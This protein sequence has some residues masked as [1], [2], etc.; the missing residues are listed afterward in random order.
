MII[1]FC[2]DLCLCENLEKP[3]LDKV[4]NEVFGNHPAILNLEGP[5]LDNSLEYQK[6]FKSGPVIS[7]HS[8]TP[9][10]L[11]GLGVIGVSLANNHIMDYGEKGLLSTANMLE[12]IGV[13][14]SGIA[15]SDNFKDHF[16]IKDKGISLC[17]IS[18]CEEE[19]G[20]ANGNLGGSNIFKLH[21]LSNKIKIFC[22]LY[23]HVIISYHGGLEFSSVPSPDLVRNMRYLTEQGASMVLCHHTHRVNSFEYWNDVPIFFGLGNF[24]FNKSKSTDLWRESLILTIEFSKSSLSV[25]SSSVIR[26]NKYFTDFDFVT[27]SKNNVYINRDIEEYKLEWQREI[28]QKLDFH[29]ST[30]SPL[31]SINNR[32]LR[33][34]CKKLGLN[35]LIFNSRYIS[36][37][38]T[39][40]VNDSIRS[41]TIEALE[42]KLEIIKK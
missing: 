22:K 30:V 12:N 19:W 6:I 1:N 41:A 10:S 42:Q 29:L 14:Y 17:V 24:I 15:S 8:S 28:Y 16:I 18:I 39:V 3:F 7:G 33:F 35:K 27:K 40:L 23:D 11:S 20:G 21:E 5:I 38:R 31:Q 2:G 26:F 9:E 34:I 32:Y 36:F 13:K 37:I 4:R 25:M